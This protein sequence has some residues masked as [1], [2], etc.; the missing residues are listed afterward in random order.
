M[1]SPGSNI[2]PASE[3]VMTQVRGTSTLA[4]Q[5]AAA[6]DRDSAREMLEAKAAQS[7]PAPA[8]VPESAPQPRRQSAPQRRSP[9]EENPMMDMAMDAAKVIGRELIRGFFG[10]RKRRP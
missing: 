10:N 5:Y 7:A 8:P 9:K 4:G 2:G 1:T 6:V 3:Q